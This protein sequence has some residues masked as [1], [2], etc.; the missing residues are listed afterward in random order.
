VPFTEITAVPGVGALALPP[1]DFEPPLEFLDEPPDE[2]VEGDEAF[3][4]LSCCANGSLLAKR[5]NDVNCPS[6]TGGGVADASD[7]SVGE[8]GACVPLLS[9]GAARLGFGVVVELATWS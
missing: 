7:G 9:V 1:D 4:S 6:A 8:P 2:G 5:L 3:S